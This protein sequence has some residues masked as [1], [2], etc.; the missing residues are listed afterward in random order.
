MKAVFDTNILIDHLNGVVEAGSTLGGYGDK[1][2]SRITWIEVLVGAASPVEEST[3]RALL[4]NFRVVDVGDQVSERAILVR[5]DSG[6]GNG[7]TL[8]VPDALILATARIENCRLI[9]RNTKDFDRS[10]PDILVPYEV[11]DTPPNPPS[12]LGRRRIRKLNP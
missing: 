8:K 9:T 10:H 3:A 2:I 4:A 12:D 11:N 7:R 1:L 5:R 6:M